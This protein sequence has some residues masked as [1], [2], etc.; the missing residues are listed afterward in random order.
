MV[1]GRPRCNFRAWARTRPCGINQK[2]ATFVPW[3]NRSIAGQGLKMPYK[4]PEKQRE[5]QRNRLARTR[6][7][8]LKENGPCAICGSDDNLE[9]DHIDQSKKV[10][11]RVWSWAEHRRLAELA[12]C[13]VLCS[14]CHK[15][16]TAA[17]YL[18][19]IDHGL[20]MYE[21]HRCRC[22]VCRLAKKKKNA[23]RYR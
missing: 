1:S 19:R 17:D 13:Q 5:Y 6:K 9:V 3:S 10:D 4:D 11:H 22:E 12:K 7:A 14:G 15:E 8:W 23:K 2:P 18:S 16:K 21:K 20:T